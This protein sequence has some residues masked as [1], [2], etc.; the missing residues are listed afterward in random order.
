[1]QNVNFFAIY[2]VDKE[3]PLKK[4]PHIFEKNHIM[5]RKIVFQIICIIILLISHFNLSYNFNEAW[6][7]SAFGFCMILLFG[8]LIWGWPFLSVSGLKLSPLLLLKSAF[9]G[10]CIIV[11]SYLSIKS[12]ADQH[13]ISIR[14]SSFK[15]YFHNAV[16]IV[17]EEII[18]GSMMLYF[19]TNRFKIKPIVASFG[20]AVVVS[21]AHYILYKFYFRDKGDLTISTLITLVLT[22]FVKNNL[23]IKFRH[24]GYAW[25]LHFGWMVVMYGSSHFFKTTGAEVTDLEKFNIYLGSWGILITSTFL[26]G[27]S[28]L[29]FR[30]QQ[31]AE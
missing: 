21:I 16:Y 23:I 13:D 5:S 17:N 11:V 28:L 14:L 18:L 9:V 2:A 4:D 22:V 3:R 6:W 12:I 26:A 15:N 24:I 30:K 10:G 27:G 31:S 29:V 20:L 25:A 19:L 7:H 1:M 8:Y